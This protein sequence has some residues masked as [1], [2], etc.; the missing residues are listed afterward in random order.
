MPAR[1]GEGALLCD[2]TGRPRR[3]LPV[4]H[5]LHSALDQLPEGVDLAHHGQGELVEHGLVERINVHFVG[6]L[7]EAFE[8]GGAQPQLP[9]GF[10]TAE[11]QPH[12]DLAG[13]EEDRIGKVSLGVARVLA[14]TTGSLGFSAGRG[15]IDQSPHEF[16]RVRP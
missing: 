13:E 4:M 11:D 5:D 7:A 3:H 8:V 6:H 2:R 10:V 1:R 16:Q 9:T 15:T 12:L 14:L